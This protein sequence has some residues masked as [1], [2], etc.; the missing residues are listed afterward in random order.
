MTRTTNV[1]LVA[2]LVALTT[3]GH[4]YLTN[5][6]SLQA[7]PAATNEILQSIEGRIGDW[8]AGEATVTPE[9]GDKAFA[10]SRKFTHPGLGRTIQ[11]MLI[12]GHSGK[13]TTHTPDICFPASGY[14][15]RGAVDRA[16]YAMPDG[17]AKAGLYVGEFQKNTA[18]TTDTLRVRWTW[19][20]DG[21]WDAPKSPRWYYGPSALLHKLYIVHSSIE[22]DPI[23]EETYRDF[24]VQLLERV[25]RRVQ[26]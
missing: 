2:G 12:S 20:A 1:A 15:Q 7:A 25:G 9:E 4:G 8:E 23:K 5:R 13:V 22:G 11:V 19:T 26:P 16:S 21:T 24:V 14:L 18:T 3:V 10:V 17:Q 6:W